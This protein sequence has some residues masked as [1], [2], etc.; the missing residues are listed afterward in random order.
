MFMSDSVHLGCDT[1]L[2]GCYDNITSE[3]LNISMNSEVFYN[4]FQSINQWNCFLKN[5]RD[6]NA[7]TKSCKYIFKQ[8]FNAMPNKLQFGF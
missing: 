8:C 2:F 6:T 7:G 1:V 4:V 5:K 3:I